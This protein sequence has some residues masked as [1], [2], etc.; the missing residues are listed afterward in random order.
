MER[1]SLLRAFGRH[2]GPS[3]AGDLRG[4]LGGRD[5]GVAVG[6]RERIAFAHDDT[7]RRTPASNQKLLL[8]M[9]LL[10]VFGA[11]ARI[12]TT[13]RVGRDGGDLYVI[14][15]GD[16][17]FGD[18]T[19]RAGLGLQG[20]SVHRLARVLARNGLTRIRGNVIPVGSYFARDWNAPGWQ[21]Y[22]R[23]TYVTRPTALS[24]NS[25]VV[26][27]EPPEMQVA[28]RVTEALEDAGIRVADEPRVVAHVREGRTIARVRSPTVAKLIE[29]MNRDSSN[30]FA[31]VLSKF[32]G[33]RCL[34]AP[35]TIAKGART[36][37]TWA[38]SLGLQIVAHDASGLSYDNRVSPRQMVTLL[39]YAA[40][41]P[42]G[43]V[44]RGALPGAG[45]G[46]LAHRL[47]GVRVA[48]KT[49]SLFDGSSALSG[50]VW[51]KGV[52]RWAAF[53]V[54]SSL[55]RSATALEDQIVRTLSSR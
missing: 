39:T 6:L 26:T 42:W 47:S 14:G 27:A 3:W 43:R 5:L 30:F 36:I 8:S 38:G 53:S 17:S 1:P 31:E 4:L 24:F 33:A 23:K 29:I 11:H 13:V 48:A 52:R 41:R 25:N 49:G 20:S 50:W 2:A 9:A 45:E 54:M 51:M 10:E 7:R 15:R 40:T 37:R 32:L 46:T 16:P 28:T 35:G 18:A 12:P 55:G 22:V 34:G 19:Y 44:L 21:S